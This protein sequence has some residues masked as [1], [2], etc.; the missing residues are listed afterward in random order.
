MT[1]DERHALS[2]LANANGN[3]VTQQLFAA[4][5]FVVPMV[6]SLVNDGLAT[7]SREQMNAGGKVVEVAKVRITECGRAAL[8]AAGG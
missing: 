7:M 3:G 4:H 5:G 8:R 6:D 1:R 2:L